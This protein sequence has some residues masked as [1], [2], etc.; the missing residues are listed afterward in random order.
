MIEKT[1]FAN[2]EVSLQF[3]TKKQLELIHN[4]VF[5]SVHGFAINQQKEI[6]FTVNPR[7]IDIVGGHIESGESPADALQREF[8]EEA[9]VLP[10]HYQLIGAIEINNQNNPNAIKKGYPIIG[11]QPFFLISQ[12]QT[13]D[14]KA[15]HECTDRIWISEDQIS[16]KHHHWLQTHQK[17]L[18]HALEC[19]QTNKKLK[20]K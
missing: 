13:F 1:Y 12:Y 2:S 19:F 9:S 3:L 14:F 18:T 11:Y 15:T 8:M 16:Q 6:L 10:I 5:T 20:F 17:A 4:P 7:G